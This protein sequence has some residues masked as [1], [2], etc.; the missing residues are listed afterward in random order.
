MATNGSESGNDE[1]QPCVD[2]VRGQ[3]GDAAAT[4]CEEFLR[5]HFPECTVDGMI[6][7]EKLRQLLVQAIDL[8]RAQTLEAIRE[9]RQEQIDASVPVEG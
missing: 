9:T 3:H 1:I 2:F 6:D 7:R 8:P 4:E 5:A